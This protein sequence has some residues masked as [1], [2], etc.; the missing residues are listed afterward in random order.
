LNIY[1]ISKNPDGP[2]INADYIAPQRQEYENFTKT[3][4][5]AGKKGPLGVGVLVFDETKARKGN[6]NKVIIIY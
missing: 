2:G 3:K 4:V 5:D 1:I 6:H